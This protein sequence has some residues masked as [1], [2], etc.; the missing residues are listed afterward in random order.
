MTQT[1]LDNQLRGLLGISS[2]AELASFLRCVDTLAG[3]AGIDPQ[4][5][6]ALRGLKPL[7]DAIATT[8]SRQNARFAASEARLHAFVGLSSDWYWEQ[9]EEY[10]FTTISAG[11]R[12][13]PS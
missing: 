10:R 1:L 3:G 7:L 8:Y 11:V 2:D 5:A 4:H 12:R 6:A 9:D 13:M